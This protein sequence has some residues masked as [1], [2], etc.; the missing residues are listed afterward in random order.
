MGNSGRQPGDA[1]AGILRRTELQR[2][3]SSVEGRDL[4]QV[5]TEIPHGAES[6]WHI[7]FGDE[8]GF[9][10]AGAVDMMI[11]GRPTLSLHAGEGFFIPPR[12]PHNAVSA[13]PEADRMLN[14]YLVEPGQPLSAYV[15]SPA[16]QGL[17]VGAVETQYRTVDGLSIRFAE[18]GPGADDAL[19]L[20]PWPE[21]F[22]AFDQVWAPLAQRA[23]LVAVDLPG[24]GGSERREDLLSPE[25]MGEF[26]VRLADV[27]GLA[28]PHVVA[29]DVGT[30]A[31]LFAAGLHPGR[32]RSLVVGSGGAAVPLEL[33]GVLKDWVTT[34]DLDGFRSTDPKAMVEG[35]LGGIQRY[36]LPEPVREDY[37]TSYEGDRMVESMRYVRAYPAELPILRDLLPR[38]TTPVQIICGG[39]DQVVPPVN[40]YFL[41]DRLP[42]SKLDILDAAH[43][44]WEDAAD[45]YAA[46]VTSWWDGGYK[47]VQVPVGAGSG[48]AGG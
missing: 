36:Q 20:S 1:L 46:L 43:Y 19:L 31:S 13:G 7:H 12:T 3:P 41:H 16:G 29:P 37:I 24:Y 21:S 9:V 11:Q 18:S 44:T 17:Q 22:L 48:P 28:N 23:H 32:L 27:F 35:A 45:E 4:V 14:T 2:T 40:G 6:G 10:L 33:G 42:A 15:E 8:A 39:R 38:I 47:R 26:I 5:M 25:A 34:P 30:A